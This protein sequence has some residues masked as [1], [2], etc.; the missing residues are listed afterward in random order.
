MHESGAMGELAGRVVGF[1]YALREGRCVHVSEVARGLACGCRCIECGQPLI[2]RKGPVRADHF[3]HAVNTTC[4]GAPESAL[5]RAAK[6]VLSE[7]DQIDLPEYRYRPYFERKS[8]RQLPDGDVVVRARAVRIDRCEIEQWIG[9]IRPDAIIWSRDR[10]LAVEVVVTNAPRRSKVRAYRRMRQAALEIRLDS[11]CQRLD[12]TALRDR[13][14]DGLACKRW[15]FHPKQTSAQAAFLART[16]SARQ[17]RQSA[18]NQALD[19]EIQRMKLP[20]PA[21]S[22]RG[23][24]PAWNSYDEWAARVI[25]KTGKAPSLADYQAFKARKRR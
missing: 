13:I 17:Q 9:P 7:L 2:A 5:H 1:A 4:R 12:P 3:S 10:S 19:Q 25:A 22:R 24:M 23:S 8:W 14:R 16:R 21:S 11:A 15:I 20:D 6:Q 18:I